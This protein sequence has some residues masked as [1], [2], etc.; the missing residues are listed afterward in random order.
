M[1]QEQAQRHRRN[2]MSDVLI[3]VPG[4]LVE[5]N[6]DGTITLRNLKIPVD[7]TYGVDN[8]QFID[9]A[10]KHIEGYFR[11]PPNFKVIEKMEIKLEL[12]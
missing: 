7:W 2:T 3:A 4:E 9:F 8:T 10:K 1:V 6:R 12:K 5:N 11:E